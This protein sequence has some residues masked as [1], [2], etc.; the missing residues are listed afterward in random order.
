MNSDRALPNRYL[1]NNYSLCLTGVK[2]LII[3]QVCDLIYQIGGIGGMRET[4]PCSFIV[5]EPRLGCDYP[6]A[7]VSKITPPVQSQERLSIY[8]Y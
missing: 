3:F 8:F 1:P 6:D 5:P 7:F 2:E 4:C